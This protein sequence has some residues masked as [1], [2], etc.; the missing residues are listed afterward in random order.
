MC[1]TVVAKAPILGP[2]PDADACTHL[3]SDGV[4]RAV[5]ILRHVLSIA[6]HVQ[7]ATRC[8]WEHRQVR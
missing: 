5:H 2:L 1:G 8:T 6:A 7:V 3:H 4:Q